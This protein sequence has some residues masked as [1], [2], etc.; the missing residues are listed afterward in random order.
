MRSF[1][2][3]VTDP[4]ALPPE[5]GARTGDHLVLEGDEVYV[6]R[7]IHPRWASVIRTHPDALEPVTEDSAEEVAK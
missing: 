4:H 5:I 7:S 2:F 3:V 6:Y 1:R